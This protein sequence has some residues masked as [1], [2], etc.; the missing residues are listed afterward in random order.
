[1]VST[2]ATANDT[3]RQ[4]S[5]ITALRIAL[6]SSASRAREGRRHLPHS[7]AAACGSDLEWPIVK[8]LLPALMFAVAC[9]DEN[10]TVLRDTVVYSPVPGPFTPPG[11]AT[12]VMACVFDQPRPTGRTALTAGGRFLA[13]T[14]NTS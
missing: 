12:P 11:R 14:P 7:R 9:Y 2:Y 1:M 8:P 4:N 3:A 6:S 10:A 13:A 5:T